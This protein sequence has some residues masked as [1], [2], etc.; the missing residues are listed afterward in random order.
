MTPT[1]AFGAGLLYLEKTLLGAD[2][3]RTTATAAGDRAATRLGTA[4]VTRFT[5]LQR[6][7][8]N[9][10]GRPSN[11]FL[12]RDLEGIAQIRPALRALST[13][14]ATAT[15]KNIAEH[16]AENIREAAALKS[17]TPHGRIHSGMPE[18]IIGTALLAIGQDLV[19]LSRL[20]E[21]GI[22]VRIIRIAIRVILHGNAAISLFDVRLGSGSIH[23]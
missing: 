16:I 17:A 10:S 4:A 2:L 7:H 23:S 8:P 12:K 18:L 20:L 14:A 1:P 21:L 9:L 5:V 6:R 22:C 19:S 15:A 11:G 3:T 13:S